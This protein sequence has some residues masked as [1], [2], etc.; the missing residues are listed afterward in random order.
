[1]ISGIDTAAAAEM[2]GVFT[3]YTAHDLDDLVE[4]CARRR[5]CRIIT[6]PSSIQ[7]ASPQI[8]SET[9]VAEPPLL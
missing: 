9:H 8:L 5:G 7:Q 6:R 1:L 3:V 4:R 2:P